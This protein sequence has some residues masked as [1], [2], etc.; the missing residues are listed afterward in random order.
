MNA[1]GSNPTQITFNG[2]D[3]DGV[4]WSPDGRLLLVQR[5]LDPVRGQSDYDLFTMKADG[6]A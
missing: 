3:D 4:R 5:D 1:D 6:T 2:L